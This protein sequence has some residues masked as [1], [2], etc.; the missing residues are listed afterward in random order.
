VKPPSAEE[1]EEEPYEDIYLILKLLVDIINAD[2]SFSGTLPKLRWSLTHHNLK[3]AIK[4]TTIQE[5]AQIDPSNSAAGNIAFSGI[6]LI[7]QWINTD[8]L[9]VL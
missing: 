3:L 6:R 8:V 9:N 4:A 7:N 2:L 5:R 1:Q